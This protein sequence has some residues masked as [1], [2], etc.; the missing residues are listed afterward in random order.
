[1]HAIWARG[2]EASGFAGQSPLNRTVPAF[3]GGRRVRSLSHE[4]SM[5]AAVYRTYG[6]PEVLGVDTVED[7]APRAKELQIRVRHVGLNYGDLLARNFAGVSPGA[8]N[9]PGLFWL[10]GRLDF[11]WRSPRRPVLGSQFAGTVT[12]VGAAV[13][14][15]KVGDDVFGYTGQ[16]MGACAEYLVMP[17]SGAVAAMP[18][19][20]TTAAAAA[21][22]YGAVM[23]VSLLRSA[24]VAAGHK[25][26]VI[27]AS[28]SIGSA[29]V[30]IAKHALGADVTGV[31]GTPRVDFVRALGAD[32]VIDYR[33][34]AYDAPGSRY[35]RII[36]VL[37][38]SRF[39]RC[40]PIMAPDGVLLYASFK[41]PQL[42][43]MLTT[44]IGRGPRVRC[45]IAP[46]SKED[47]LEVK[48]LV[49]T[50]KLKAFV[51]RS[52][53]IAQVAEAHRWVESGAHQG[54]VV[55]SLGPSDWSAGA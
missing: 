26:L 53:P 21:V 29:A 19:N 14:G 12:A 45:A 11:G 2:T 34:E 1:M 40:R 22:P 30:Q 23:A 18:S 25:L 49:E 36:D 8:F 42:L 55:L 39:D 48:R 24:G 37:G 50:E 44:A 31:C 33:K 4:V 6:G 47:L 5:Q 35:D 38:R 10:L 9:M 43:S 17:E 7:R 41:T 32:R 20:L 13:R 3:A 15:F 54:P 27:G 52:F 51:D 16:T 28:G 46:G